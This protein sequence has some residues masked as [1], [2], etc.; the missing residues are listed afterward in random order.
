MEND[1]T[2][3]ICYKC[4]HRGPVR[5]SRH[6][7]CHHPL[8]VEITSSSG[9]LIRLMVGIVSKKKIPWFHDELNVVF[10]EP[11]IIQGYACWPINFD[12]IWLV[13]CT[14]FEEAR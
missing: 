6:S 14:G 8:A 7:S 11:G 5:N 13:E 2:N 10:A 1:T 12:P 4:A 3:P 9:D